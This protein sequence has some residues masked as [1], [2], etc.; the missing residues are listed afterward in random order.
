MWVFPFNGVKP[1]FLSNLVLLDVNVIG[2]CPFL[3][4]E[5]TFVFPLEMKTVWP[6]I[7]S[8][9]MLFYSFYS[10]VCLA[11]SPVKLTGRLRFTSCR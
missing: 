5:I 2:S 7:Y 11:S 9:D 3:Y 6:A 4:C 8:D 1:E 10:S